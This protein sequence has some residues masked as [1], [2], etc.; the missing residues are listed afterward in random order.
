[1]KLG[2]LLLKQVRHLYSKVE[3]LQSDLFRFSF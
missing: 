1:M 2:I 3:F